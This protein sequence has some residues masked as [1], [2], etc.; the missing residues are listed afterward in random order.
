MRIA[1]I[2][3]QDFGEATAEAFLTRRQLDLPRFRGVLSVW[4]QTI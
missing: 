1:I 3:Q 4:D 2:A